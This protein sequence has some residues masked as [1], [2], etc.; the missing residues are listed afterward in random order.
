M[1]AFDVTMARTFQDPAS[2]LYWDTIGGCCISPPIGHALTHES[3][4]RGRAMGMKKSGKESIHKSRWHDD[5]CVGGTRPH[6]GQPASA[7]RSLIGMPQPSSVI[8]WGTK[9]L[10]LQALGPELTWRTRMTEHVGL[11]LGVRHEAPFGERAAPGDAD[12]E[13]PNM[14]WHLAGVICG[15]ETLP[16][17]KWG[18]SSLGRLVRHLLSL[19]RRLIWDSVPARPR[20]KHTPLEYTHDAELTVLT[21]PQRMQ[22]PDDSD[23]SYCWRAYVLPYDPVSHLAF[24]VSMMEGREGR[25]MSMSESELKDPWT[26]ADIGNWIHTFLQKQ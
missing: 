17:R 10:D 5:W 7:M 24:T 13:D 26:T 9:P 25:G 18:R 20:V 3:G 11:I 1:A 4:T 21:L 23:H 15:P 8:V 22:P 16:K 19:M 12:E 6:P 14:S 2:P